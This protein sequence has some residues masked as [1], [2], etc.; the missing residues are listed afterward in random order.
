MI[1]SS[2]DELAGHFAGADPDLLALIHATLA[3][4]NS[5]GGSMRAS[6]W[7]RRLQAG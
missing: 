5:D 4:Q 2:I 7:T 6:R 1:R 3:D